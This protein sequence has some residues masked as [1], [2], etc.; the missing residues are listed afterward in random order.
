M[1]TTISIFPSNYVPQTSDIPFLIQEIERLKHENAVLLVCLSNSQKI[2][3]QIEKEDM[4]FSD[5]L[6]LWLSKRKPALSPNTYD[7]YRGELRNH[8]SPYFSET[9]ATLQTI[10]AADIEEFYADRLLNGLSP[11]TV[12]RLHAFIHT[13]MVYA[14]KNK[15]ILS[16]PM[17]EVTRPKNAPFVPNIY[18]A[19]QLEQLLVEAR[20]LNIYVP[21][22]LAALLGLRRS[23]VLGLMWENINLK[24]GTITIKQ[25]V[26]WSAGEETLSKNLKTRSSYRSLAMPQILVSFLE[27]LKAKQNK[28]KRIC[29]KSKAKN[30]KYICLDPSGD[31]I[32]LNQVTV[33]FA[34]F[35]EKQSSLPKIRFHDLRHSCACI[36]LN[37]GCNMKQIQ[38]WLGHSNFAFTAKC[39]IH[40]T[41]EDKQLTAQR[42]NSAIKFNI[43]A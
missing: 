2:N 13:A 5:F 37:S 31:R 25:K 27:D 35:M 14:T 32:S 17:L 1:Q 20:N 39:Y 12:I 22:V 8:L 42:L 21:I 36:L 10:T 15:M 40:L 34:T 24:T 11:N 19:G 6:A 9:G 16:N 3:V 4:P 18:N 28:L 33:G 41:A 7:T 38:D 23:E 29:D 30:F 43:I 26:M